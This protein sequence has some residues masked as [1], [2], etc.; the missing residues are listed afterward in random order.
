MEKEFKE[1]GLNHY[2]SKALSL[3]IQKSL[4][5]KKL[6]DKAEIPFGKVYSI[7]KNLKEKGLVK[8]NN[9]RPKLVYV[10]D[11]SE[12]VSKLI[13]HKKEKENKLYEKAR[14]FASKANLLKNKETKF[15]QIGTTVEEN[16][17]IQLRSFNEANREVLQILN[18]HHKPQ[19]NRKSKTSWEKAISNAINQGV[20]FKTIYPRNIELPKNIQNL[21]KKHPKY[22]Q[23][24]RINTDFTRCDI[25]DN[26]KVMIKLVQ[27]D[28]LQ[29]G[30]ILFI[31]NEKLNK[32]LRNIF[33]ELWNEAS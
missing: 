29:F 5:L 26:E 7:V 13:N 28:P 22:F 27:K 2:E 3:L 32:N 21:N 8:E 12:I 30:G 4:T 9:S 19:S 31:E 25:V 15:F 33:Y 6:S 18:I 17:E 1:L 11:A 23:I 20:V 14:E 16:K 24:K 10:D